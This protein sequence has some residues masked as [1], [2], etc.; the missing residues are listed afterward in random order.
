M[1]K[2]KRAIDSWLEILEKNVEAL[3]KMM[4]EREASVN[5]NMEFI[6]EKIEDKDERMN[7]QIED[8]RA[9]LTSFLARQ[10]IDHDGA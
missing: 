8:I 7:Q 5:K 10:N 3:W 4:E 1:L 9:M 2:F 6:W